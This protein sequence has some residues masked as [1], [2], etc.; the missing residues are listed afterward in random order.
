MME[1]KRWQ[2]CQVEVLGNNIANL[3]QFVADRDPV[4]HELHGTWPGMI[5]KL[6]EQGWELVTVLPTETGRGRNPLTY[7]FKRSL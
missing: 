1:R 4:V 3:R 2:F 5:G 7:V 6:G